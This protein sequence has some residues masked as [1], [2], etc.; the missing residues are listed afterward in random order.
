MHGALPH[1]S[2]AGHLSLWEPH[3]SSEPVIILQTR[4]SSHFARDASNLVPSCTPIGH[5]TLHAICTQCDRNQ[6]KP[7]ILLPQDVNQ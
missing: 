5:Q 3:Q 1:T 7:E 4:I 6:S 2:T